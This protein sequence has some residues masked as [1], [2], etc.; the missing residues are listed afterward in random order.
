MANSAVQTRV[1]TGTVFGGVLIGAILWN[2]YSFATLL[3]GILMVSIYEYHQ[4]LKNL[5][6]FP[7]TFFTIAG[8]LLIFCG[9]IYFTVVHS[10]LGIQPFQVLV[11]AGLLILIFL[12]LICSEL[13]RSYP[14]PIENIGTSILSLFY[15]GLPIG[16]LLLA[17]LNTSFEY[18]PWR[19]LFFFF[20]MWASDT[21]AYF[22]GRLIG[23]HKLFERHSPK[24]TIEGLMGGITVSG[25]VGVA[26]WYFLGLLPLAGWILIGCLL[27]LTGTIGDLAESMFK[28]QAGIKDSGKIL[29]GHGGFLDRFDSTYFS[30]PI[31][32]LLL[33]LLSE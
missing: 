32:Y 16:L 20:F 12:L 14:K 18:D 26:A 6:I 28:R 1:I 25:L 8:N 21:G 29:P 4:L 30:A 17:S 31:Y 9:C 7:N 10:Y 11:A 2:E 27:A 3:L 33:Q 22:T 13:F 5:E 15:F 19:V 23:K 24:K